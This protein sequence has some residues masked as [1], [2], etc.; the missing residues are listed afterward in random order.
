M[1]PDKE[2]RRIVHSADGSPTIYQPELDVHFHSVH[3]A[4]QETQH[5]FITQGLDQRAESP[6]RIFELGFGTGLN[7]LASALSGRSI[8]YHSIDLFPLEAELLTQIKPSDWGLTEAA[9][10]I[11]SAI[12]KAPWKQSVEISERFELYKESIGFLELIAAEPEPFHLIYFDAFAPEAQP[13]LWTAEAMR[14]AHGLLCDGGQLN[15]Y[16]AQGQFRRNLKAAGFDVEKRPGPPG[17][18]EMTVAL[19]KPD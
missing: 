16:C 18:R 6:L 2:N 7:A 1:L 9:D 10:E 4:W 12:C 3:G 14:I 11:H 8:H 5:V 13:E 19:K 15:T 17:K